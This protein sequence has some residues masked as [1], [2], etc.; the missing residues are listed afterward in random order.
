VEG[1]I[2]NKWSDD[3]RLDVLQSF[4]ENSHLSV[5][6]AQDYDISQNSVFNILKRQKYHPYKIIIAQKLM[7]D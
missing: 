7:K 6:K 1:K 4:Q 3:K 5:S 2:R